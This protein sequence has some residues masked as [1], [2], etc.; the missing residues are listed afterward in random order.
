LRQSAA[1]ILF[2]SQLPAHHFGGGRWRRDACRFFL[3]S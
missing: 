1:G 2:N 3:R